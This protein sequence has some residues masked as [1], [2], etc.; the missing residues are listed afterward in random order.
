MKRKRSFK[1]MLNNRRPNIEPCGA[2]VVILCAIMVFLNPV[3][4]FD[5]LSFM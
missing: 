4:C 2:P 5:N 3:H 1:K